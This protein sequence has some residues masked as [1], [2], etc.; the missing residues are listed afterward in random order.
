MN[1]VCNDV[2]DYIESRGIEYISS[3]KGVM[4]FVPL[5]LPDGTLYGH[6]ACTVHGLMHTALL[7]RGFERVV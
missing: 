4:M 2:T 3:D 7:L 1:D 5:R 6:Q